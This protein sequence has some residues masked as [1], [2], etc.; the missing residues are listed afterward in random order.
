M[1]EGKSYNYQSSGKTNYNFIFSRRHFSRQFEFRV[2]V[3]QFARFFRNNL[4]TKK[5]TRRR[6]MKPTNSSRDP[7]YKDPLEGQKVWY[8]SN[9]N[10]PK[11][12]NAQWS[13]NFPISQK[14]KVATILDAEKCSILNFAEIFGDFRK[15]F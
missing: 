6:R 4:S 13:D 11:N 5:P 2:C 14:S 10:P 3:F 9:N 12:S 1:N 7:F 8:L 15:L